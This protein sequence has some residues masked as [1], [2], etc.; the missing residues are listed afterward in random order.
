M[1][2]TVAN[3]AR[4]PRWLTGP[5]PAVL[6]GGVCFLNSLGNGFAYDDYPIVV[7]NPRITAPGAAEMG[8]PDGW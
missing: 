2:S 1:R 4:P 5:W 3:V 8:P 6:L 7:A